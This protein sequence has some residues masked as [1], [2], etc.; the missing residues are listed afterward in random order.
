MCHVGQDRLYNTLKAKYWFPLMYSSVLTYVKSCEICQ[1]TK[2]STHRK[3]AP[4][5][6]L[7]VVDPFG[8]LHLDFV[9]PLPVTPDKYRHLLVIVDSTSLFVEAVPTK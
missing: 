2:A 6:P 4:L 7:E 8:R 5:K 3:K 1:K 9:G